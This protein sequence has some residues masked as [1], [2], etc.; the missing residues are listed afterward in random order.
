MK[1]QMKLMSDTIFGNGESIPGAED[2]S[3]LCDEY[4][5]PY[6]K[7]GTFKGILREEYERYLDWM[8]MD[9]SQI[10]KELYRLFGNEGDEIDASKL[11]FSDFTLSDYVKSEILKCVGENSYN[12]V[13]DI[14]TNLRAFT[15][16]DKN[17]VAKEGS[18]RYARCVDQGLV[19]YSEV[20]C[21]DSDKELFKEIVTGI[22]W[23]GTMRNRGFGNV[24]FEIVE[25]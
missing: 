25:G 3:V 24:A 8:G 15:A 22:K 11:K 14:T 7:G 16:I 4:G 13:Q 17:G 1:I 18:L 5:F 9:A 10:N 2:I 6:F 12:M 21:E 23:V 19:F 20:I